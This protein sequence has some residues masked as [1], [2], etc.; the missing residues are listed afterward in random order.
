MEL[1]HALPDDDPLYPASDA[2]PSCNKGP[3]LQE[4]AEREWTL[5]MDDA[6]LLRI[7]GRAADA[8]RGDRDLARDVDELRWA[9]WLGAVLPERAGG[10]ALGQ[11]TRSL[12]ALVR[13]LRALGRAN[14]S[15]ARLFEGHVN[16]AKLV[17]LYGNGAANAAMRKAVASGALMGVWGAEGDPALRMN[18]DGTLSG[19]KRFASGLGLVDLAVVS[20]ADERGI[21]LLLCRTDDP[22]RTDA[23]GWSVSGMRATA[24][25]T[26][27]FDGLAPVTEL[28]EPGDYVRE[29]HFEGGTWRYCAAH[30][31][32]AE[33]LMAETRRMLVRSKRAD[34]PHQADRIAHMAM[35]CE[36]A[37]LWIESAAHRVEGEPADRDGAAAYALLAREATE[38]ACLEVIDL[39][40]RALGMAA[41]AET[42]PIARMRRDLSMFLRQAAPD[43]KRMRAAALLVERDTRAEAL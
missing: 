13:A 38:R 37:R 34:D 17:A 41:H 22:E 7:A 35:A 39:A 15:V 32:G 1:R 27:R 43:A 19:T 9:G 4:R 10:S 11:G 29:P 14:L 20:L 42:L 2:P 16:A 21:R 30:L 23:S 40:E 33:A 25:G 36:T 26:F 3:A 12:P 24:S 31:G 6:L 5:E 18:A 28:G 8:D